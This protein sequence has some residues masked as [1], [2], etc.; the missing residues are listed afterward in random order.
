M[1]VEGLCAEEEGVCVQ[2]VCLRVSAVFVGV[3][4]V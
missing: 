2:E 3:L 1:C 4:Y